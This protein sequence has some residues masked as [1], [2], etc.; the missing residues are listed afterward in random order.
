[1]P[2]GLITLESTESDFP[3]HAEDLTPDHRAPPDPA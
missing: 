2:G 1:M 3:Q